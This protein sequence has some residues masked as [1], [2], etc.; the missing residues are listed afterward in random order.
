[1]DQFTL[2]WLPATNDQVR[3][4]KVSG[5]FTLSSVFDFQTITREST[6]PIVL[7]DLSGVPYMDSASLGSVL[8]FHVSC[9]RESRKY[10]LIG[11]SDRLK[12]LFRISGVQELLSIYP[13]AEAAEEG[14]KKSASA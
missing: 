4:L 5:P 1:M 10:A 7:I 11:P 9:Q 12:T 6:A 2:E 3:T 8:G 14:L 13:T